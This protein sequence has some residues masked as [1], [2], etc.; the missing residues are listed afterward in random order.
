MKTIKKFL[1]A[2]TILGTVAVATINVVVN[3][4]TP[5]MSN[6]TLQNL[7][8]FAD[9]SSSE[10]GGG[11]NCMMKKDPCTFTA[12]LAIHVAILKRFGF[13]EAALNVEVDITK[14]TQIYYQKSFYWPTDERVRCGQDVT[15]ND[16]Q[17]QMGLIN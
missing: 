11:F 10:A 9:E 4:K 3:G 7:E 5:I 13:A 2:L 14:G 1:I 17:R 12:S 15:C 6:V 8:A 16:Y